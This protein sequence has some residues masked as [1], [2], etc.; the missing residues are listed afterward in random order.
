MELNEAIAHLIS[1][2]DIAAWV[3]NEGILQIQ[4][5]THEQ[6]EAFEVLMNVDLYDYTLYPVRKS[7]VS[8]YA[9]LSE[10]DE[11]RTRLEKLL[12]P[13]PIQT[14]PGTLQRAWFE[15]NR[16]LPTR[17]EDRTRR[18]TYKIIRPQ[19]E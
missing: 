8:L 14:N 12:I 9:A 1:S 10:N 19:K 2:P 16:Y 11:R 13:L 5:R 17:S 3:D 15:I 18:F 4:L 7:I 6:I